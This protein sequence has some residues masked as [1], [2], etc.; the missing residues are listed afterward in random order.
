MDGIDNSLIGGGHN[1]N[2][3]GDSLPNFD[4][5]QLVEDIIC[6][7]QNPISCEQGLRAKRFRQQ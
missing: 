2:C 4:L 5:V 7:S 1:G 3:L 6:V